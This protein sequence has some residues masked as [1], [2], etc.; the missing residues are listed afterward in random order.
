MNYIDVMQVYAGVN[1]DATRR[2]Y[3]LL[4]ERGPIGHVAVNLFRCHKNSSRAKV[5]RRSS[6][7]GAAYDT[8]QWAMSNLCRLL[9]E[10][11]AALGIAWGWREDPKQEVHRWVLYVELPTGQVSFHTDVRGDGPDYAGEWDGVKEVGHDRIC[12][13]IAHHVFEPQPA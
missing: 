4:E 9:G 5:Y 3:A 11:A 8:K 12:R 7:R 2:L 13:F 6:S 10:H 1:G